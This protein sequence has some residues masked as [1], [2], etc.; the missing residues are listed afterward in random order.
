MPKYGEHGL[1]RPRLGHL[2]KDTGT[3]KCFG[4]VINIFLPFKLPQ[5]NNM[6]VHKMSIFGIC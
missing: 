1:L 2:M 4:I 3:L 5:G 6:K